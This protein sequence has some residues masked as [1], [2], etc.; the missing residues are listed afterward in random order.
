MAKIIKGLDGLAREF[1]KN[2]ID[3]RKEVRKAIIAAALLV[4][5]EAVISVQRG[6]KTGR[7]Y[8]KYNPKRIHKASAK[9]QAPA[10]DT[11]NLANSIRYKERAGLRADVEARANYSGFLEEDL[12]RPFMQPALDKKER[13]INRLIERAIERALK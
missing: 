8:K 3:I 6:L 7:T 5:G 10:S 11:G 9:G 2:A 1:N 4:E 13:E 12:E